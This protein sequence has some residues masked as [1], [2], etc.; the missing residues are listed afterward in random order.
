MTL[1]TEPV[2]HVNEDD[3]TQLG[4]LLMIT[5]MKRIV[6]FLL[7]GSNSE[8]SPAARTSD[9]PSNS[10]DAYLSELYRQVREKTFMSVHFYLYCVFVCGWER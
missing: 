4:G 10:N 2:L 8:F 3:G 9:K 5:G 7:T 6:L 1:G